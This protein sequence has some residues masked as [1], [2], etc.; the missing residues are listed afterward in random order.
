MLIVKNDRGDEIATNYK[1]DID[2]DKSAAECL[3]TGMK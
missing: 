2:T 1:E 3:K